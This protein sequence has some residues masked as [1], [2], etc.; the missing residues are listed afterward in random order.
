MPCKAI[1][2]AHTSMNINE[3]KVK[4]AVTC[5]QFAD[6]YEKLLLWHTCVCANVSS[7][8]PWSGEGL[9]AGGAH[10]GQ[11][12]W[13]DVHLKCTQTG[14]LL[15]AV[16]AMEGRAC[17]NLSGQRWC[18]LQWSA[19][20]ELV[21]GYLMVRQCWETG[22]ALTAVQTVVDVLDDIRTGGI[23]STPTILLFLATATE[24]RAAEVQRAQRRRR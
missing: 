16:F 21:V 5:Q 10:T 11:S 7:K 15:G 3:H 18:L 1:P 19:M 8:Q 9:A 12:V 20:G 17:W 22:V 6:Q 23:W 2:F 24:G 14:V 13:A 4:P